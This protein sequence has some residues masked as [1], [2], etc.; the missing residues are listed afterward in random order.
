MVRHP[1]EQKNNELFP[2]K[3]KERQPPVQLLSVTVLSFTKSIHLFFHTLKNIPFFRFLPS[4]PS[5]VWV[6]PLKRV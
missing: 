5:Q 4:Y 2:L 6:I 1:Q 3:K